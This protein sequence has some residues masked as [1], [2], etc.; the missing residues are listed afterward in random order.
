MNDGL[1]GCGH[2]VLVDHHRGG[3]VPDRA[4]RRR[5][6]AGAGRPRRPGA[7]AHGSHGGTG[8]QGHVRRSRRARRRRADRRGHERSG[9]ARHP[10]AAAR[11]LH[12]QRLLQG[13][14]AVER[15]SLFPLQLPAWPRSAMGRRRDADDRRLSARVRRL[16]IL[17][18]RLSARSDREPVPVQDRETALR[19]HARGRHGARRAHRLHAGDVAGLERQLPARRDED[20][21]VVPRRGA[22]DPHLPHAAHARVPNALRAADVP[23]RRR[24]MLR[25]GRLPIASPKA[26]CGASPNIPDSAL[27]S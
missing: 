13:S 3:R 15:S 1:A 6:R 11:H 22:A 21:H 4:V 17:R 14:R 9:A 25:S 12:D 27:R 2:V 20:G 16:G 8:R 10:A 18:P 26:S 5:R 7:P 19:S 23:L 24:P